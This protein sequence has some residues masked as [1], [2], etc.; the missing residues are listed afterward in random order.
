MKNNLINLLFCGLSLLA[1]TSLWGQENDALHKDSTDFEF[2]VAELETNY[3][4]FPDKM[5]T[6]ANRKAYEALKARCRKEVDEE[7]RKPWE[8]LGELYAWFGDF[9]LRVGNYS[10][11]Y[12]RRKVPSYASMEDYDPL[13]TCRKVTDRTF[14][15]RFPS[16]DGDDP[17][18]EWVEESIAAYRASGCENL[19][20]DI[21]G[22]GGG[23]DG[24][25]RPYTK[26][27]YDR[28]AKVDGVEIRN[29]PAHIA[30]I[31]DI[32]SD[33]VQQLEEHM[34]KSEDEFVPMTPRWLEISYDSISPLPRRA[35]LIIDGSVAS[36]GEQ[37][38]LTLRACSSRTTVYGRDHTMGCLD[39]S[40]CRTVNL[41]QSCITL[42]VPMTRSYRLPDRGID[43]TGIAPDVRIPLP[44]PDVLTDNVDEWT[45]W[46]AADLEKGGGGSDTT[47]I[48]RARFNEE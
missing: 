24:I 35:A 28:E 40:N 17:T 3:A 22:N 44:L 6:E 8:A 46:V 10:A 38:V 27:L 36:S 39:Y 9:H 45:K 31:E 7:G 14:L 30:W 19:I 42:S 13:P 37:M 29:T 5:T 34:R 18:P 4:G 32:E 23:R 41:P 26:L 47:I 12:M 16:C 15:I 48:K 43:P 21:R 20:I 2:G 33:W 1:C 25:F 11:P